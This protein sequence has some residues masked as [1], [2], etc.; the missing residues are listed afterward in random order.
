LPLFR[1][2]VSACVH[3]TPRAL[4]PALPQNDI[5]V[6]ANAS[7]ER[8]VLEDVDGNPR[9]GAFQHDAAADDH[10][11]IPAWRGRVPALR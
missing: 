6:I 7:I 9:V 10:A 5:G 11:L 2:I 4:T 1:T 3:N 8:D